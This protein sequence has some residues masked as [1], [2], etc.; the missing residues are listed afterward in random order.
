MVDITLA[1]ILDKGNRRSHCC[2]DLFMA[3]I[4]RQLASSDLAQVEMIENQSPSP[5]QMA[6]IRAEITK[7]TSFL[8]VLGDATTTQI[9]GWCAVSVVAREAELLKIA[10]D[11]DC[12]GRGYGDIFLSY[13]VVRLQELEVEKLFL[14]V[15]SNNKPACNLYRKHN[16]KEIGRRKAYYSQ[17]PDDALIFVKII[18]NI[19]G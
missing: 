15:R 14:E 11:V 6:Q 9:L 7:D 10:V 13:L 18:A 2:S 8:F 12:R 1:V 5:W 17:P 3:V 19:T 16:F 4:F